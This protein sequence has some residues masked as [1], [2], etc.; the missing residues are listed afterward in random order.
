MALLPFIKKKAISATGHE[1]ITWG[2][3]LSVQKK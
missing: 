1:G 3:Y 2:F